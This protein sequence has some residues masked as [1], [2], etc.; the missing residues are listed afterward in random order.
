MNDTS[1]N[2]ELPGVIYDVDNPGRAHLPICIIRI[3][4]GNW[5]LGIQN[6]SSR[7]LKFVREQRST[8]TKHIV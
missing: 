8:W 4:H 2:T 1:A 7:L 3:A 5:L 6:I